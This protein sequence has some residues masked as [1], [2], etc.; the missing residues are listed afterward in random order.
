L[1]DPLR[2]N[3]NTLK[4]QLDRLSQGRQFDAPVEAFEQRRTQSL[5]EPP[6][7][8]GKRGLRDPKIFR[9]FGEAA[10]PRHR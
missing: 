4:N 10:R 5:F 9:S 1:S 6:D 7:L 3:C 8:L 2:P